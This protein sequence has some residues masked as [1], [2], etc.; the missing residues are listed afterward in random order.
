[1]LISG[2]IRSSADGEILGAGA[3]ADVRSASDAITFLECEWQ[4]SFFDSC[5]F[6]FVNLRII[7]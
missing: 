7:K 6:E 2:V 4:S 3:G 5:I 1:M